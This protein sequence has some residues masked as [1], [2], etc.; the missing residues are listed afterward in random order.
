MSMNPQKNSILIIDDD[1]GIRSAMQE[2]LSTEGYKVSVEGDGQKGLA[3]A[4]SNDFSIVISDLKLPGMDGLELIRELHRSK[5]HLPIILMTAHGTTEIAIEAMKIGAYD[6]IVKPFEMTDFLILLEKASQVAHLM[7]GPVI[8]GRAEEGKEALVGQSRVMQNVYKEIGRVATR[9]V[10]VL[11]RGETGTG[12][13]LVARAIYQHSE[14]ARGPFIAL[15]CAAIPETLLESELFGH[16]RGAF[17]GA[18]NRRIGRFEQA[19]DGTIFLD[20]IGDI[21]L[22]TQVKLL[23]VLQDRIIQRL[24]GKETI[25]VNVRVVAATHRDLGEA[26]NKGEFRQDLFYRLNV[27][28]IELPPLR[29]RREDIPD[30]IQYFLAKF[31]SDSGMANPSIRPEV[32]G[33]LQQQPWPGNVRELEN[34]IRKLLV[35]A[36]GLTITVEDLNTIIPVKTA[37]ADL[38]TLESVVRNI[39]ANAASGLTENAYNE[40][41]EIAERELLQQSMVL[42]HDNQSK[43]SRWLGISRLTLREKLAKHGL[44]PNR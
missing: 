5:P 26:I 6:Y 23:R 3:A 27:F 10:T 16:E 14:R 4:L 30:L 40:L 41:I 39:L 32:I 29:D 20:E 22:G 36:R 18:E 38:N 28:V 35:Q 8:F 15:N 11:I 37:P 2:V 44:H 43:V 33:I 7:S 12:K 17:T 31:A 42:A 9:P 25:P 24:G 21:S 13:E 19:H 34:V 1:P